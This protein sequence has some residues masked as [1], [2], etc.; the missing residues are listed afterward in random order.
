MYC[1]GLLW[2]AFATISTARAQDTI[3]I[4]ALKNRDIKVVQKI[5]YSK[6]GKFEYGGHLAMMPFDAYTFT[7]KIDATVGQHL[8]EDLSWEVALGGGYGFKNST[9]EILEGP[10]YAITPTRIA[11]L[12]VSSLMYNMPPSMPR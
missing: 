12:A 11:T 2:A 4:G 1:I 5:L 9:Y 6:K 8:T 7:G 10:S 3:D